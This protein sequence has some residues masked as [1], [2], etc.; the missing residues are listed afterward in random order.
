MIL[1]YLYIWSGLTAE[2]LDKRGLW[3]KHWRDLWR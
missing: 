1:A 2:W 3:P